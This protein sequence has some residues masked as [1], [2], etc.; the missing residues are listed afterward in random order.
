VDA[1][2]EQQRFLPKEEK[3]PHGSEKKVIGWSTM[4][5]HGTAISNST[6]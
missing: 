4:E 6:N 3:M 1:W 5:D 2:W